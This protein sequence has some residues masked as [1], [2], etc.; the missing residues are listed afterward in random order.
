MN[1]GLGGER[2][3]WG[4]HPPPPEEEIGTKGQISNAHAEMAKR[5]FLPEFRAKIAVAA[6][7]KI[8]PSHKTKMRRFGIRGS[9]SGKY[10]EGAVVVIVKGD[11]AEGVRL[12]ADK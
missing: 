9:T 7:V 6:R 8:S 5:R 3:V 10:E 4:G 2:Y 1:K 11:V 12:G